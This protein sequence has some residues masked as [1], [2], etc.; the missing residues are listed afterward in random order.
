MDQ[1]AIEMVRQYDLL[2]VLTH[3]HAHLA[4]ARHFEVG[5]TIHIEENLEGSV[6]GDRFYKG[7]IMFE[8]TLL[9]TSENRRRLIGLSGVVAE[10][11]CLAAVTSHVDIAAELERGDRELSAS[12]ARLAGD[13]DVADVKRCHILVQRFWPSIVRR[14]KA[15]Q[16][17][18]SS[19]GCYRA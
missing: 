19:R 13:Y 12:D 7:W 8:H 6:E 18:F 1:K 15:A 16:S 5:G 11:L 14:V 17:S 10:A 3:E 9:T 2:T 4:V